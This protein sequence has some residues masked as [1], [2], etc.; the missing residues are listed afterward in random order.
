MKFTVLTAMERVTANTE[1]LLEHTTAKT[2]KS[3]E[4]QRKFVKISHT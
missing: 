4:A 3:N 2:E 1:M